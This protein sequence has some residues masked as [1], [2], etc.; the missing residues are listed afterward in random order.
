[1]R[2]R[3]WVPLP[4]NGLREVRRASL[5][6]IWLARFDRARRSGLDEKPAPTEHGRQQS[7]TTTRCCAIVG[8]LHL[9]LNFA[10][11]SFNAS[12]TL[13]FAAVHAG[14]KPNTNPVSG[15]TR[16]SEPQHAG[17]NPISAAGKVVGFR[18]TSADSYPRGKY[19]RHSSAGE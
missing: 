15:D 14:N 7:S 6:V 8:A 3:V 18:A 12:L 11:F 1:V 4:D 17:V 2:K 9:R 16:Q 5:S 13:P 19:Y 10:R